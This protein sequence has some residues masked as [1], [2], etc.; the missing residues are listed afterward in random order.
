[1][2]QL[3]ERVAAR[4]EARLGAAGER[5]DRAAA[6]GLVT[7]D[8][9]E[10]AASRRDAANVVRGRTGREPLV[11]L[12]RAEI[13]RGRR[14][15]CAQ[16]RARHH[17][18]GA[19]CTVA[20]LLA[21]LARLLAAALCEPAQ[22]VGA[23]GRGLG[24]A[25]DQELHRGQDNPVMARLGGPV[26][27][28]AAFALVAGLAFDGGGFRPVAY[29]RALVG[30]S[31]LALLVALAAGGMR[32]GRHSLLLLAGLGGLT[33]WTAS[34]W[35]W[36]DSPPAA[37]DEAQRTG[38]YLAIATA[39]VAAGRRVP[40]AWLAGGVTAGV[41]VAA[42]WNL[43]LR[44]APDWAG[45]APLRTD[46]GQL[47]D[48][49]GYA[50]GIALLAAVGL[51]L[52]L[53][54]GGLA[55][56]LLV[57]LAAEV[58]LQQS[59]G[60]VAALGVGLAAYL[61]TAAQPLRRAALLVLPVGGALVVAHAGSVVDPPPTD[62]LA[63][64][65]TG[66]RL[67]L[68]L[69]LLTAAQAVLLRVTAG[70]ANARRVPPRA[71]RRAALAGGA[72]AVA[73]APLAFAHHERLH[74]WTAAAHELAGNPVLGSGAGTF[75]DW[76]LRVR[77]VPSSALEAHSLYIET[78]AELGPLGLALLLLALGAGLAAAW[79]LR[80]RP[81]GAAVLGALVA[82]DAAA[83]V[84]FHW[85]LAGVTAPAILLAA[86]AAVHAES[87]AVVMRHRL[88]VPALTA[89]AAAGVL[90]L[91]GNTALERGNPE[92]ALRFAPYSSSAWKLIG[93]ARGGEGDRAGAARAYR[94]ALAL[95]PNDWSAW[96]ALAEVTSGEPRRSARAEAARLNPLGGAP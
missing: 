78:L 23:P 63:A 47:G 73:S 80:S 21:E 40:A 68:M 10:L 61:L 37:L 8:D 33:V 95:D 4:R 84:D 41:S 60:T 94:R 79:R 39:V 18:V 86:S 96:V 1:M 53:G 30:A 11:D 46:I 92:R 83:A 64:G 19:E 55:T 50:N 43:A 42:A 93:A 16:Q 22:L 26:G 29:D 25:N 85:E 67:L 31:A 49:V 66:H 57:P 72:V 48:P 59:T 74:Y 7:H 5:D 36:S 77:T 90:A 82:Y 13:E 87:A 44:L 34:S 65:R 56:L 38:A 45:R 54:L 62:L 20:Q 15:A 14:L 76:W 12:R 51:V 81:M 52:A 69:V 27:G 70:L 35:L 6:V 58:A 91:A 24:V 75:V 17:R 2:D 88:V 32:A 89:F 3:D 9:D 28:A 71:A